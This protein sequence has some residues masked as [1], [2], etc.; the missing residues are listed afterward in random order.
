MS[1]LHAFDGP[2]AQVIVFFE[3]VVGKRRA[4]RQGFRVPKAGAREGSIALP[5]HAF[6]L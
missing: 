6:R 5:K 4:F 2:H 3:K 1:V